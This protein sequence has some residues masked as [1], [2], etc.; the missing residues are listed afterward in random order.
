MIECVL[1]VDIGTTSLKAGLVSAQ[2]EV[3]S[4]NVRKFST[5]SNRFIARKWKR[6]LRKA[7]L[8][9]R[10][11][12]PASEFSIKGIAISGNGPTVV[13]D[14]GMTLGWNV[15]THEQTVLAA[16]SGGSLFLPRFSAFKKKFGQAFNASRWIFSGPEF[17]IWQLTGIPVSILPEERF[18]GAYWDNER[19]EKCGIPEGKMPGFVRVGDVCGEL[20]R[21]VAKYLSLP[22]GI[23]VVAGGPDFV[24]ALIGTNTLKPGRLCDRCGSSEGFNFCTEKRLSGTGVR[25][26]PSVIPGLWNV[27]VLIPDS[28]QLSEDERVT[29]SV[30]AL[31]KLKLLAVA[32]KITFPKQMSATG[33][34]S[35]NPALMAKKAALTGMKIV[36]YQCE[37]AEL[38]GD[39]CAAWFAL[40]KYRSLSEAADSIV[41]ETVVYGNI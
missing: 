37:D 30:E 23:P 3:V 5:Y 13:S 21:K 31:K 34:Q 12:A 7:I 29:K 40:G 17:L 35:K 20:L 41:R 1:S 2:G 27:S 28:S 8:I 38:L 11:R 26:L 18:V 16:E 14:R 15:S 25:S 22:V 36:V 24:V 6:A 10:K 4:F 39:A 19:L 9:M 33:G 32:N